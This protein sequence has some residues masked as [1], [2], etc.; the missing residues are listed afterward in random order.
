MTE[1]VTGLPYVALSRVKRF[2]E[3]ASLERLQAVRKTVNFECRI[4]EENDLR[5]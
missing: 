4:A 2:L 1:K 3:P 5:N